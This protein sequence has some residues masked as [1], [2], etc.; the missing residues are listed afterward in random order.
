MANKKNI[1]IVDDSPVWLDK[2]SKMLE[3]LECVQTV[4]KAGS[5]EEAIPKLDSNL[6]FIFLDIHMPGK[7]GI[8]LLR[9]INQNFSKPKV[10]MVSN[11]VD[12]MTPSQWQRMGAYECFDK[13]D[14]FHR[15]PEFI[16]ATTIKEEKC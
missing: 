11:V 8:E 3:G 16:L 12:M 1:L 9:F 4:I 5:Y 15:I 2:F 10:C 14:D 7:S 6:D 13:S